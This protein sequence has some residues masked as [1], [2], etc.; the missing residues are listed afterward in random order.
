MFALANKLA[1][2]ID[3]IR[4]R[5]IVICATFGMLASVLGGYKLQILR[6]LLKKDNFAKL[7]ITGMRTINVPV[8]DQGRRQPSA[9]RKALSYQ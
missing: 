8:L 4:S 5:K 3:G 1:L 7:P 6:S 2:L 9:A